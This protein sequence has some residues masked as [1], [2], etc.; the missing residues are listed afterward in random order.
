MIWGAAWGTPWRLA[1]GIPHCGAFGGTGPQAGLHGPEGSLWSSSA[2]ILGSKMGPM[3]PRLTF[4]LSYGR[5]QDRREVPGI[6]F[7]R[8]SFPSRLTTPRHAHETHSST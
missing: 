2:A 1:I 3:I 5:E 8:R 6:L 7:T 4:G